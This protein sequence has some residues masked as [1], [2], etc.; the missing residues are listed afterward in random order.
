MAA[1]NMFS[2]AM[3]P[4]VAI[5][6]VGQMGG[7]FAGALLRTGHAVHPVLRATPPE[8][9]AAALPHP[10][11]ALVTVAE[12]DLSP[13]LQS[14]PEPWKQRAGLIQNELL[15]RDWLAA[16]I[17]DPTVAVVW[18]E[19]K[20]G[21]PVNVILPTPVAGRSAPLLVAA[22]EAVEIPAL[23]IEGE[24]RLEWELVRKN[25]YIL[26]ANIAGLVAG[27]TVGQLWDEHRD[28]V[29]RVA[30][31]VLGLQEWL[32]GHPLARSELVAA[33]VAAFAADPDHG[34]TGRSAPGRLDRALAH[35]E[36]AGLAAPTLHS[37]RREIRDS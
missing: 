32:V 3:P 7:V 18:F 19:K 11:L 28:L 15:P 23:H 13:V 9:V 37:I 25:L 20:P 4:P 10:A 34:A 6:G 30:A 24:D 35:A 16:G 5:I 8:T 21:R 12:K 2:G 36:A 17:V 33:M 27:G 1:G 14:L 29:E 26:T 22:L 31:E